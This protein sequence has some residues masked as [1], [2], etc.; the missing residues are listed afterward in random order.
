VNNGDTAWLFVSAAL[1][2]IMTPALAMFY[3]GMVRRK[4]ILSTVCL[5]CN[6]G[7]SVKVKLLDGLAVKIQGAGLKRFG[8]TT[9]HLELCMANLLLE[10][11]RAQELF[12][13]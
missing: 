12:H 13:I 2:M 1:V 4:N 7:C 3:G 11:D 10:I 6:T 9:M 5:Q 8:I